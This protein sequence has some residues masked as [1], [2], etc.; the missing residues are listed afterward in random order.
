MGIFIPASKNLLKG[1]PFQRET[2]RRREG[3][4]LEIRKGATLTK[5]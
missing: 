3:T 5:F 4:T 2:E 1:E